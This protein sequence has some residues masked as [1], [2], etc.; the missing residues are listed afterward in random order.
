MTAPVSPPITDHLPLA[1]R[2]Y[3]PPKARRDAEPEKPRGKRRAS[4]ARA[5]D[6]QVVFDTE[7]TTDAGQ[8][9][10]F[11]AYQ[12]RHAGALKEAGLFYAP[13]GVTPDE[14]ETLRHHA[15]ANGLRLLTRDQFADQI[16]FAV[17]WRL[18]A[19]IIGFNLPFDISRIAIRHS[20]ARTGMRGGFSFKLSSQKI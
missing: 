19:T 15:D 12:V 7:T 14:M 13:D 6:W 3:A 2:A 1:I 9:L 11:G 20:S 5:S 10:R 4:R 17:G 18:R 8:A 16:V